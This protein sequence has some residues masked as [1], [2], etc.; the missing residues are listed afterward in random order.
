MP[1]DTKS[2]LMK[3]MTV[4]RILLIVILGCAAVSVHWAFQMRSECVTVCTN[5]ISKPVSDDYDARLHTTLLPVM[6]SA[7]SK[8]GIF[9]HSSIDSRINESYRAIAATTTTAGT[10]L[11]NTKSTTVQMP[12]SSYGQ[13]KSVF[14][15][16]ASGDG[17]CDLP[18]FCSSKFV[19]NCITNE[20]IGHIPDAVRSQQIKSPRS[21]SV[22][23]S[24]MRQ[25]SFKKVFDS[26]AWGHDWDLQYRGLNA[27]GEYEIL[28]SASLFLWQCYFFTNPAVPQ[29]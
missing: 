29:C 23:T 9:E 13:S 4:T 2:S 22:E 8:H 19:R 17:K 18:L 3:Y 11:S 6:L 10:D 7:A 28:L 16:P 15:E 25:L 24:H 14:Q 12:S 5:I 26:R 27:S 20:I 1:L 21:R